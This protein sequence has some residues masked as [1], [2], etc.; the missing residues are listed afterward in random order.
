MSGPMI[1]HWE[2]IGAD[3]SVLF[4]E[5]ASWKGTLPALGVAAGIAKLGPYVGDVRIRYSVSGP[6]VENAQDYDTFEGA[7]RA[8]EA[9]VR[10]T[11]DTIETVEGS[12][13]PSAHVDVTFAGGLT[14]SGQL[15]ATL[16]PGVTWE[17]VARGQIQETFEEVV[18][19]LDRSEL[20]ILLDGDDRLTVEGIKE[21][22]SRLA[23]TSETPDKSLVSGP[24]RWLGHKVDRFLDSAA[25]A[26][27][28]AVGWTA[29]AGT[30]YLL[31]HKVGELVTLAGQAGGTGATPGSAT[32][33][34][35]SLYLSANLPGEG[36]SKLI[37]WPPGHERYRGATPC[38][39][40]R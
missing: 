25:D 40:G 13:S 17:T 37:G 10:A 26:A 19:L 23:R 7:M 36:S 32:R 9:V 1:Y 2:F 6:I 11:G 28:K 12:A 30:L 27:G 22:L 3:Q 38:E 35:T 18:T 15:T 39:L 24:L 33:Y 4:E 8:V 21:L 14:T 29:V 31:R 20:L 34:S 5:G 16:I